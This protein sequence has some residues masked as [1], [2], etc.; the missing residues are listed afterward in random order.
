MWAVGAG[1]LLWVDGV[2]WRYG[3]CTSVPWMRGGGEG[4][5]LGMLGDKVMDAGGRQG[6]VV[7]AFGIIYGIESVGGDVVGLLDE[8][9]SLRGSD[10]EFRMGMELQA[11]MLRAQR[12]H[13]GAIRDE[14]RRWL[15]SRGSSKS[16]T[17]IDAWCRLAVGVSYLGEAGEGN[18]SEMVSRGVVELVHVVVQGGDENDGLVRLAHELAI[19]GLRGRLCFFAALMVCW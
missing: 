13:D 15:V 8:M 16:G 7:R 9:E 11:M 3:V 6:L 4:Q 14:A 5:R 2:D 17:W 19:E 18:E 12:H 10:S 1:A